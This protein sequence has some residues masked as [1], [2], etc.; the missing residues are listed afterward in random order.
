M[1]I[2]NGLPSVKAGDRVRLPSGGAIMTVERVYAGIDD[3]FVRC[4][5]MDAW[6]RVS[7]GPFDLAA[8]ELAPEKPDPSSEALAKED[9]S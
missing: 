8:V 4:V 7:R 5:W 2:G 1:A 6:S 9:T 3:P